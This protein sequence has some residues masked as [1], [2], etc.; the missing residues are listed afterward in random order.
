MAALPT[1]RII[2]MVDEAGDV[3]ALNAVFR[4]PRALDSAVDN[5]HAGGIAAAVAQ[6]FSVGGARL[7]G[8]ALPVAL[9]V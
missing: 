5:F 4:M 2:T 3:E 7:H 6:R 9:R 1:V 8:S